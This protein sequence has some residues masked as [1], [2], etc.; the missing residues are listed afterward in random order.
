MTKA[1]KLFSLRHKRYPKLKALISYIKTEVAKSIRLQILFATGISLILATFSGLFV[2]GIL[3]HTDIGRGYYTTYERSKTYFEEHIIDILTQINSM[4]SINE[5]VLKD[6]LETLKQDSTGIADA[7][8]YLADKAGNLIYH[9]DYIERIDLIKVIQKVNNKENLRRE[10]NIFLGIYPITLNGEICYLYIEGVLQGHTELYYT[11]LPTFLGLVTGVGVFI[12]LIFKLTKQ[13]IDYIEYLSF[14]LGEISKGNLSYNIDIVGED[15]LAKVAKDIMYMEG[16]IKR[17]VETKLHAEKLKNELVTNVAHDLRTPLTSV[18]GYIGLVKN[19]KYETKEEADKYIDIA[20]NKSENLRTLIEDLFEL[21]KLHQKSVPLYKE[22]VSMANLI[23]QLV[24]E[25]MPVA[26][27]K[28]ID[29]KVNLNAHQ[30]LIEADIPKITRVLEN[31]LENAIKYS[32]EQSCIYVELKEIDKHLFFAVSN[33][34]TQKLSQEE[35]ERLFDRFYRTDESR[36]SQKGGSGLG[37]AIAKE[38]ITLHGGVIKAKLNG[39][40][41]SFMI[42]LPK[43]KVA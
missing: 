5:D 23:G 21:T 22:S 7:D 37:L 1:K 43:S 26:S 18:I 35:L 15:E 9:E 39:E 34:Y 20:Y 25:F 24:Q 12:F 32:D 29:I 4:E 19:K 10:K 8:Y 13:K 38:I 3:R 33:K 17:Q 30:G 16:E 28:N 2:Q 11:A 6:F 42:L 14:C 31:L 40:Y 27:D 41:I 36:N